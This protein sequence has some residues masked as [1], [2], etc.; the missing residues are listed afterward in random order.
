MYNYFVVVTS[1]VPTAIL[2][3]WKTRHRSKQ[4][5][6]EQNSLSWDV[7]IPEVYEENRVL[8]EGLTPDFDED[9]LLLHMQAM[10]CIPADVQMTAMF[11][12]D[13]CSAVVFFTDTVAGES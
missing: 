3:L 10:E 11:L 1:V 5:T 2:A 6:Y 13:K 9:K 12:E 7:A 8:V 4:L